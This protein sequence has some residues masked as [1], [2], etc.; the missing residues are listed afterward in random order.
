MNIARIV[1]LAPGSIIV[2]DRGYN[3]YEL[4]ANWTRTGVYFVTR[5]KDNADYIVL[6]DHP[7]AARGNIVCDETISP[8]PRLRRTVRFRCAASCQLIP[9]ADR[10]SR[11]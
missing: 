2:M 8:L 10:R 11:C 9:K 3:D 7:V 1:S 4:F 6:E 5:L